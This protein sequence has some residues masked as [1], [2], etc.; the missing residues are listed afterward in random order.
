MPQFQQLPTLVGHELPSGSGLL[1]AG[2][3]GCSDASA[4]PPPAPA[5][6][7]A[8]RSLFCTRLCSSPLG[9]AADSGSRRCEISTTGRAKRAR[10]GGGGGCPCFDHW[11]GKA[12]IELKNPARQNRAAVVLMVVFP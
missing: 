2:G 6:S 5:W 12:K 4:A 8:D 10:G 9:P 7:D 11:K 3:P 1:P